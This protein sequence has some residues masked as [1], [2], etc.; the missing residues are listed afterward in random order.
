MPQSDMF[1]NNNIDDDFMD[2]IFR[3]YNNELGDQ[4]MRRFFRSLFTEDVELDLQGEDYEKIDVP[5]FQ[6]GTK[7]RFIHDFNMNKTGIV[8]MTA[9]RCFVMPLNRE[10]VL[11]PRSIFDLINKMQEGYY[12]VDTERVQKTMRIVTPALTDLT[13][14]GKYISRECSGYSTYKLEKYVGGGNCM[15]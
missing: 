9:R 11:P 5:D 10:Y 4:K 8:D 12:N 6:N 7:G 14:V 15:F 3:S 1:I 2:D 13:E